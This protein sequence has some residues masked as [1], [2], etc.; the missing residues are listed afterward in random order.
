MRLE[1]A[2]DFRVAVNVMLPATLVPHFFAVPTMIV[3]DH[4]AGAVPMTVVVLF[5]RVVRLNP[6]CALIRRPRPIPLVP[7]VV[8]LLGILIALDPHIVVLRKVIALDPHV[9]GTGARRNARGTGR[10]RLTDADAERELGMCAWD[11]AQD[12][13]KDGQRLQERFPHA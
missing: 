7:T 4:A 12:Y 5:A 9:V 3:D 8:A 13:H 1:L 6:V 10:W 2:M 11:R